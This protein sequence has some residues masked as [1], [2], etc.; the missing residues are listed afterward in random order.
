[1]KNL[2]VLFTLLCLLLCSCNTST[3][4][5]TISDA[6][7]SPEYESSSALSSD[8]AVESDVPEDTE[9]LSEIFKNVPGEYFSPLNFDSFSQLKSAVSEENDDIIYKMYSDAGTNEKQ[10][11]KLKAFVEKFRTQK[12]IVPHLNGDVVKLRDKKDFSNI[13]LFASELY[14]LPW[15]WYFPEVSTGENFYINITYLPD[16]VLQTHKAST[17]SDVIKAISPDSPNVDKMGEYHK[18]IY[19]KTIKLLDREVTALISEY[20]DDNR[21]SMMF[22]YDDMLVLVRYNPEI[23]DEEWFSALSFDSYA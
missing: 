19:N 3:S 16:D 5:D 18:A 15:V 11:D 10:M 1:M 14:S 9:P 13:S 2:I 22:V 4:N 8:E 6:H 23:W 7:T 20:K 17:A 21:N 12:V